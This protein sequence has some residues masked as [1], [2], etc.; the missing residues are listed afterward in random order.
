MN[1]LDKYLHLASQGHFAEGL[2]LIEEIVQRN[3]NM[4]TSQFNYGICLA[5]LKRYQDASK[6]FLCA[7]T[8]NPD[9]GRAL[10]RACLALT[11][12][13]DASQ[14]LAV[15]RQECIRD[16]EMIYRFIEEEKFSKFWDLPNFQKLKDE[17]KKSFR[18]EVLSQLKQMASDTGQQHQFDF[19]LYFQTQTSADNARSLIFKSQ[20]FSGANITNRAS[21]NVWLCLVT[22]SIYPETDPLDEIWTFFKSIANMFD[23][24]FDGW[25]SNVV[26]RQQ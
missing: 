21:E 26:P 16:P 2:P 25:E 18:S 7:Y 4:A 14:L 3:P 9:D 6:A 5:E 20:L 11:S 24:E 12:A 23:G 17:F 8:L 19:Y 22:K 15:F 1:I 10:Y 13:D